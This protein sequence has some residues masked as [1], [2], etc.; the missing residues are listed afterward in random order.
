MIR[1]ILVERDGSVGGQMAELV[2]H[3][4][5]LEVVTLLQKPDV[6]FCFSDNEAIL[7]NLKTAAEQNIPMVACT[8][9][10][11]EAEMGCIK[12]LADRAR[13]VLVPTF[14]LND[15][16]LEDALRAAKWI[17]GQRNGLY[18]MQDVI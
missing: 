10:F 7:D 1:A 5:E 14:G 8:S 2:N 3:S 16:V 4:N 18:D 12:R 9:G 13:C 17:I 15:R 11:S 6:I